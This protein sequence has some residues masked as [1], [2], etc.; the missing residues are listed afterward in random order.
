MPDQESYLLGLVPFLDPYRQSQASINESRCQ[1]TAR[2][3]KAGTKR[4]STA[5]SSIAK[6][7]GSEGRQTASNFKVKMQDS[8]FEQSVLEAKKLRNNS[9]E[10]KPALSASRE[11]IKRTESSEIRLLSPQQA[12]Q[13]SRDF[14]TEENHMNL[15]SATV[16]G[17]HLIKETTDA[18]GRITFGQTNFFDQIG[19]L[20]T[21]TSIKGFQVPSVAQG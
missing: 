19:E 6:P 16:I 2:R 13:I 15:E 20:G 18:K 8:S 12:L 5:F 14:I 21:T 7:K 11:M 10:P 4:C 3:S 17:S 1:S 9:I